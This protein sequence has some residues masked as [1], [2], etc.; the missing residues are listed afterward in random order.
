MA[1]APKVWTGRVVSGLAVAFLLFDASMKLVRLPI[2]VAATEQLGFPQSS[3]LLLGGV[4]LACTAI[5]AVPRTAALG[6]VLL[7]GYLGGAVAAHVRVGNPAFETVF[8]VIVGSLIWGGLL[9]R[10]GHL[11]ATLTR[12]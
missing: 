5:Y 9:L 2:V 10:D 8:P 4:L 11:R 7:T 6:A 3:I 12:S 1:E